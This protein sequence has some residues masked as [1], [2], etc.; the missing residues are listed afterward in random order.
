MLNYI[1]KYLLTLKENIIPTNYKLLIEKYDKLE[2]EIENYI[3]NQPGTFVDLLTRKNK[4]KQIIKLNNIYFNEIKDNNNNYLDYLYQYSKLNLYKIN[5]DHE[6]INEK[7]DRLIN[8]LPDGNMDDYNNINDLINKFDNF[9]PDENIQLNFKSSNCKF[10]IKYD[11]SIEELKEKISIFFKSDISNNYPETA[12][13]SNLYHLQPELYKKK[14]NSIM[15]Q[16]IDTL[17][18]KVFTNS[19]T[20]TLTHNIIIPEES[21]IY[22]KLN[23]IET[24]IKNKTKID[25]FELLFITDKLLYTKNNYKFYNFVDNNVVKFYLPILNDIINNN[26]ENSFFKFF[27]NK[28]LLCIK[29]LFEYCLENNKD[30]KIINVEELD[31]NTKSII[32]YFSYLR[33][34]IDDYYYKNIKLNI[35]KMNNFNIAIKLEREKK[36]YIGTKHINMFF[37]ESDNIFNYI[38]GI[39]DIKVGITEK[40]DDKV[41][42]YNYEKG[43]TSLSIDEDTEKIN[44][45]LINNDIIINFYKTIYEI[46]RKKN[47]TINSV[48]EYIFDFDNSSEMRII[49]FSTDDYKLSTTF[50]NKFSNSFNSASVQ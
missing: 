17:P 44:L 41:I 48:I 31:D 24:I 42:Y 15:T 10:D 9:S 37:S 5:N 39:G 14:Y 25:L 8:N 50:C 26:N 18:K 38:S 45:I 4:T 30:N 27:C 33:K 11:L 28:N 32:Y 34:Y 47:K 2:K 46:K 1:K 3:V 36:I 16:K 49:E 35:T 13:L 7:I 19:L 21:D 6:Y 40:I 43:M 12:D 20:K 23:L 29:K 22:E